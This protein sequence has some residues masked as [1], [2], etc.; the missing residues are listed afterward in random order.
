MK[1]CFCN[2]I[3]A[4]SLLS[5]MVFPENSVS[6]YCKYVELSIHFFLRIICHKN[7]N[8]KIKCSPQFSSTFMS[9]PSILEANFRENFKLVRKKNISVKMTI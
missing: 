4:Y 1:D 2:K 3:C 6:L 8:A 9:I 7:I 5:V